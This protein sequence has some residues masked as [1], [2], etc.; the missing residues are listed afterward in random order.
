MRSSVAGKK[1]FKH[2]LTTVL[3]GAGCKAYDERPA[4]EAGLAKRA[5]RKIKIRTAIP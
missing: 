3:F 4:I 5:K 1:V 2:I